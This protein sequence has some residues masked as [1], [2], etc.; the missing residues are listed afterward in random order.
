MWSAWRSW[1][2]S[3]R[4]SDLRVCRLRL[5]VPD[6]LSTLVSKDTDQGYEGRAILELMLNGHGGLGQAA[7][8]GRRR[9]PLRRQ[10]G[11]CA[12]RREHRI[13]GPRFPPCAASD[14]VAGDRRPH[15][16]PGSSTAA[17]SAPPGPSTCAPWWGPALEAWTIEDISRP[18]L[19]V[20]AYIDGTA[21]KELTEDGSSGC[22]AAAG[23]P[24]YPRTRR[25]AG[26][27][28]CEGRD[29]TVSLPRRPAAKRETTARLSETSRPPSARSQ[30]WRRAPG[31]NAAAP[32]CA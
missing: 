14:G 21:L 18:L 17:V 16:P 22:A 6:V 25:G 27:A 23:Q 26:A 20:P 19:T 13:Q 32:R 28:Q 8:E 7:P 15:R 10:R 9:P 30:R 5:T 2:R 29:T 31:S 12:L 1:S 24:S 4:A 11:G 3:R